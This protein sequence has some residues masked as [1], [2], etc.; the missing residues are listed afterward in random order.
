MPVSLPRRMSCRISRGWRGSMGMAGFYYARAPLA[1][2]GADDPPFASFA[3]DSACRVFL[4]SAA[5]PPFHSTD[6]ALP[7]RARVGARQGAS[8]RRPAASRRRPGAPR[9]GLSGEHRLP[10]VAEPVQLVPPALA[11]RRGAGPERLGGGRYRWPS[12]GHTSGFTS[13][14]G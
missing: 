3:V 9:H 14:S 6:E 12:R 10:R 5:L 4:V 13:T 11:R 1:R 7:L 2:L 8:A